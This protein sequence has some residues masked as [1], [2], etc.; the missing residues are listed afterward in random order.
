AE[1]RGVRSLGLQ[2]PKAAAADDG[3]RRRAGRR[4]AARNG[5]QITRIVI[6][7]V[8]V[9]VGAGGAV[10]LDARVRAVLPVDAGVGRLRAE[11]GQIAQ[12]QLI[13]RRG[14]VRGAVR[15]AD[16][17]GR[18][19]LPVQAQAIGRV[20][21]VGVIVRPAP[22]DV[23]R[24][25]IDE[26]EAADQRDLQFTEDLDHRVFADGRN[27]RGLAP[28]VAETLVFTRLVVDLV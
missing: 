8:A 3:R 28:V 5:R 10:R 20:F 26:G 16:A 9:P 11:G 14:A 6:V 23:Q 1:G 17:P 12:V 22:G 24:Q 18:S 2:N 7:A 13:Q 25:I 21:T 27:S 4:I 19:D 15:G